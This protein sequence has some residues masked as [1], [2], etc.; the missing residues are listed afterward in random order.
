MGDAPAASGVMASRPE[1]NYRIEANHPVLLGGGGHAPAE[2]DLSPDRPDFVTTDGVEVW[3]ERK[4]QKT[5]F[6]DGHGN[7]VGPVHRN[8]APAIIW[9]RAHGWRDPSLPQWF[10]DAVIAEV[11]AGG[12]G[13]GSDTP[14]HAAIPY[15]YGPAGLDAVPWLLSRVGTVG[16]TP[17]AC[18]YCCRAGSTRPSRR[19][20]TAAP[21]SAASASPATWRS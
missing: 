2:L 20:L 13:M 5:R 4:G 17:A 16:R 1:Q 8:L 15:A 21:P 7:Q 9:A 18:M 10:N 12:A 14:A 19:E 6:L 3:M 11:S